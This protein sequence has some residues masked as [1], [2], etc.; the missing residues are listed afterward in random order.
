MKR[1]VIVGAG[2]RCYHMF[3]KSIRDRFSD[4][5]KLVGVCDP[6]YKR[7]QIYIDTIDKDMKYYEDFDEMLEQLKP[8]AVLVTT[9]DGYHH[10]YIIKNNSYD[11]FTY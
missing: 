11:A 10:K 3:A 9:P 5:C 2:F 4:R 1:M 8:D 6:N 7:A